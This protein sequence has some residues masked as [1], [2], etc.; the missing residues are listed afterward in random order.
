MASVPLSSALPIAMVM[1]SFDPG[2]TERQMIE[3]VR[4]LDR[5]RWAVH[6]AC[7][8]T[9]GAWFPRVAEVAPVTVFPVRSFRGQGVI[10][11]M[12]SFS[13]WCRRQRLAI[14]H[15]ASLPANIF[16]LPGAALAGVPVRVGNRR[17]INP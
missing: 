9:R 11:K 10:R 1:T 4:R 5:A 13:R 3:L 8:H 6:V 7:F 15:T 14:V 12:W 16:G 2:G 17:E